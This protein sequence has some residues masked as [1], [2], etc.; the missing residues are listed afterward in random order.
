MRIV[1]YGALGLLLF[2][3]SLACVFG[4]GYQISVPIL[5]TS[6]APALASP[7]LFEG[8]ITVLYADGSPVV[9]GSDQVYLNL[10][11]STGACI[12]VVST[13]KPTAPGAYSYSFTPPT[14]LTGVVTVFVQSGSLEDDNGRIFPSVDTQIAS[15]GSPTITSSSAS[16]SQPQPD[17]PA[18]PQPASNQ[19]PDLTR[20]A[21]PI[22]RTQ[23][24]PIFSIALAL[25]VV[26]MAAAGLLILP[27]RR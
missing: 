11:S 2:S 18:A 26:V 5:G 19:Q 4:K 16:V 6:G 21:V 12:N 10:C 24:S 14:S 17:P 7:T 13:L 3:L 22:Q 25:T 27:R 8:I 20:Q 9:L 23:Q 1:R 15:Y